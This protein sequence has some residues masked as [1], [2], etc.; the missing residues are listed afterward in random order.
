[1]DP[2]PLPFQL[3]D[4]ARLRQELAT[5]G[6]RDIRVET[7]IET[8]EFRSGEH[9]WDWLVHS[10]P[11]VGGVLGDLNLPDD[12]I[13]V[14]RRPWTA[15]SGSAP[16]GPVRHASPTRLTSAS[17]PSDGVDGTTGERPSTPAYFPEHV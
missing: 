3:A 6:L 8:T 15:W 4:P 9:F 12:Q 2:L 5:A 11:I 17:G 16:A 14:V 1:M 13:G 10:N 7:I